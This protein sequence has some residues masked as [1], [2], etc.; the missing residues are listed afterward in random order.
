VLQ[1]TRTGGRVE[2]WPGDDLNKVEICG[3]N[4]KC[5]WFNVSRGFT[6]ILAE[7]D[8]YNLIYIYIYTVKPA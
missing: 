7:N 3:Y 6:A 2:C 1:Y 4:N 8:V 5:Q